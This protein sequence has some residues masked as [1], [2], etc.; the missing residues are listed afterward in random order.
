MN[1]TEQS[2]ANSIN[3]PVVAF[4]QLPIESQ[5]ALRGSMPL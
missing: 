4:A 3:S 2:A 1:A 5:C